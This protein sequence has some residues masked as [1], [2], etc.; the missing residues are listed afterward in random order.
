MMI[1]PTLAQDMS[2]DSDCNLDYTPLKELLAQETFEEADRLTRELLCQLA[3]EGAIARQWLYFTEVSLIPTTD[4][5]TIDRLWVAYS[6][7]KFGFSVQRQLWLSVKQDWDKL[8]LKWAGKRVTVGLVT[9]KALLGTSAHRRG[10]YH[11]QINC[12]ECGC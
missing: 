2:L 10:I 1:D 6:Q 12:V 11:Y 5:Q 4:L 7:G 9:P 3:G 8:Y